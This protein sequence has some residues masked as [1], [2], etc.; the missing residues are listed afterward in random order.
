MGGPFGT[1]GP[2]VYC[3]LIGHYHVLLRW[4]QGM[5]GVIYPTAPVHRSLFSSHPALGPALRF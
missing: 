5:L 3:S 1:A 2:P 4:K